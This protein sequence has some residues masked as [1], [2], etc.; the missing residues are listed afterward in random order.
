MLIFSL[1]SIRAPV[2]VFALLLLSLLYSALSR[3]PVR[4]RFFSAFRLS[5]AQAPVC[6]QDF[7][8]TAQIYRCLV[9]AFGSN[10]SP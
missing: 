4:L 9:S 10:P 3:S 6:S 7:S 2:F 1:A 8:F 5:P